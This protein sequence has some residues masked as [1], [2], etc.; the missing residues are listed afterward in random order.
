MGSK[1]YEMQVVCYQRVRRKIKKDRKNIWKSLAQLEKG[2]TFA[3]ATAKT[4]TEILAGN[5][6]QAGRDS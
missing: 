2:A 3:P 1:K 5:T 6:D 4:F